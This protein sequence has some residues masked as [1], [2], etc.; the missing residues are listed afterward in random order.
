VFSIKN[1]RLSYPLC[2][3]KIYYHVKKGTNPMTKYQLVLASILLLIDSAPALCSD[4]DS[5]EGKKPSIGAAQPMLRDSAD[6]ANITPENLA[7]AAGVLRAADARSA[8]RAE[9]A[10]KAEAH[11]AL[12]LRQIEEDKIALAVSCKKVA[13]L[14]WGMMINLRTRN[15]VIKCVSAGQRL[16]LKVLLEILGPQSNPQ[17]L[18][19]MENI[20][21]EV[22]REELKPNH[23]S[24]ESQPTGIEMLTRDFENL[25]SHP[26]F[27][28]MLA[29]Y[30]RYGR[31]PLSVIRFVS[32]NHTGG[33][34]TQYKQFLEQSFAKYVQDQKKA[35]KD[36]SLTRE[37]RVELIRTKMIDARL[38]RIGKQV[39]ELS[40]ID[41]DVIRAQVE[42]ITNKASR[43]ALEK[44]LH[45][46]QGDLR[47]VERIREGIRQS[48]AQ[49]SLEARCQE[50][51]AHENHLQERC[52]FILMRCQ[53]FLTLLKKSRPKNPA[54]ESRS[55]MLV[56]VKSPARVKAPKVKVKR[57]ASMEKLPV[58]VSK[59]KS[60][61]DEDSSDEDEEVIPLTFK[62]GNVAETIFAE[63]QEDNKTFELLKILQASRGNLF[64]LIKNLASYPGI[65][66]H[67]LNF[68]RK[69]QYSIK[70][71]R[72]DRICFSKGDGAFVNVEIVNYH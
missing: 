7:W 36:S 72:G 68:D 70:I 38:I 32:K 16:D 23:E 47:E 55:S 48:L 31:L 1:I 21:Y 29:D 8:A 60:S 40:V 66:L 4:Q 42:E 53:E 33:D 30:I 50:I 37:Q 49:E 52:D 64:V 11:I 24:K 54:A 63:A 71:N 10:K 14:K 51:E 13:T 15:H 46:I 62:S 65:D 34:Q 44:L 25:K 19:E 5:P 22:I 35:Y 59:T 17:H 56:E 69:G 41:C 61:S 26:E 12:R 20:L 18:F 2:T 67:E 43:E 9:E 28:S 27:N 58:V 39:R 57:S 45:S 3:T 6:P